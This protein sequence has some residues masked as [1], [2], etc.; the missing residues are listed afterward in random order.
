MQK[1]KLFV[2]GLLSIVT[3]V[4]GLMLLSAPDL[5]AKEPAYAPPCPNNGCFEDGD[6]FDLTGGRCT[7]LSDTFCLVVPCS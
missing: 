3:M 5:Q 6:C 7:K 4:S 1:S 2:V